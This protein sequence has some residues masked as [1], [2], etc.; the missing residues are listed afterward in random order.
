MTGAFVRVKRDGRYQSVEVD[1]LTDAELVELFKDK[2]SAELSRWAQFA[3]KW[4]RDNVKA[5]DE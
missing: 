2:D 5:H 1:Q 3:F 4:I